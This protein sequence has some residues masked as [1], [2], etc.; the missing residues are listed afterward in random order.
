MKKYI[1]WWTYLIERFK[2]LFLIILYVFH[3]LMKGV[4]S[5]Y[6]LTD[7][8]L[9]PFEHTLIDLIKH[10]LIYIYTLLS[11]LVS[12]IFCSLLMHAS[13]NS[14]TLLWILLLLLQ[15]IL[16]LILI[17]LFCQHHCCFPKDSIKVDNCSKWPCSQ[18]FYLL[19]LGP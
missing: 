6:F 3:D 8:K 9:V 12:Y 5:V 4:T 7:Y 13:Q 16:L 10:A 19:S 18:I 15:L 11:Q 14:V 1:L 17:L 2:L